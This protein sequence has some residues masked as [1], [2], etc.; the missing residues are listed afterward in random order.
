VSAIEPVLRALRAAGVRFVVVG[1]VAV[2]LQGHARMTADLDLVLDLAPSQALAAMEALVALGLRP[3][4]PVEA[5]AFADPEQRRGWI[6]E[7]GM[8]VFSLWDPSDP[9]REI[10]IFVEPPMPFEDLWRRADE[11]ELAGGTVRVACI[12]DLITMKAAAGRQEDLHDI[13]ALRA[14]AEERARGAR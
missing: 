13:E 3:R 11:L 9:L 7:K 4:A 5:A 10:D 12:D 6:E 2:V 14:I 1:G 8:R